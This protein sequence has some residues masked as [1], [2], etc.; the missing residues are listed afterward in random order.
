LINIPLFDLEQFFGQQR[1]IHPL[2][3]ERDTWLIFDNFLLGKQYIVRWMCIEALS[4]LAY[5]S[6]L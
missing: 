4:D 6:S 1:E 2:V 5:N 3:D